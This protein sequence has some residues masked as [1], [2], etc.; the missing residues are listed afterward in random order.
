MALG[1]DGTGVVNGYQI[2]P[3][4]SLHMANLIRADLR[5]ADLSHA[6]LRGAY[7]QG[8]NLDGANLRHANLHGAHLDHAELVGADLHNADLSSAILNEANLK[9]AN[10]DRACLFATGLWRTNLENTK[11]NYGTGG[12]KR[13]LEN[14]RKN[15]KDARSRFEAAMFEDAMQGSFL[16]DDIIEAGTPLIEY[17][18]DVVNAALIMTAHKGGDRSEINDALHEVDTW[19]AVFTRSDFEETF[20]DAAAG[21]LAAL[22]RVLP[23][24]N[25]LDDA[26]LIIEE[27]GLERIPDFLE[28][29]DFKL[30][31]EVRETL[32]NRDSIAARLNQLASDVANLAGISKE[33]TPAKTVLAAIEASK[34]T[35]QIMELVADAILDCAE[36]E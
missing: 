27:R 22:Q 28:E 3:R 18:Y 16:Y 29:I 5:G 11:I 2:G 26:I 35:P 17:L 23:L 25:A 30:G 36:M 34:L 13:E 21:R 19:W 12:V 8:A 14:A 31:I 1:P 7:L 33:E 9:D 10:L 32:K 4:R 24:V 15:A 6:D 20:S